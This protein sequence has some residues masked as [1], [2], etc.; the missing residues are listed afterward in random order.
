MVTLKKPFPIRAS[1]RFLLKKRFQR[2]IN[3]PAFDDCFD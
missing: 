2:Q 3:Q 1:L